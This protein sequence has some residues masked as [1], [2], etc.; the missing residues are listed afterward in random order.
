M[1]T[2]RR[3]WRTSWRRPT[4]R[5]AR[6]IGTSSPKTSCLCALFRREAEGAAARLNARVN[7]AGD[8]RTA[9]DAWI[10]EILSFGHHRVKASRV[11]VLGSPAAM[12]AEG[13]AEELRLASTAVARAARDAVS[14]WC[15]RRVVPAGRPISGCAAHPIGGLGGCGPQPR[16]ARCRRRGRWRSG[17]CNRSASEHWEQVPQAQAEAVRVRCRVQRFKTVA[18]AQPARPSA[19]DQ[20][21]GSPSST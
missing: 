2:T 14:R 1:A 7:A 8:P 11:S 17:R 10:D 13:Y 15:R 21:A 6:S 3:P 9:L 16:A 19:S 12:K 4:C 5:R 18:P 20:R